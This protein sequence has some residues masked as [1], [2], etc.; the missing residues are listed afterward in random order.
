M[1]NRM[2]K[3]FK[4]GIFGML[5]FFGMNVNTQTKNAKSEIDQIQETLMKYID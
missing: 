2:I 3:A 1:T 4:I 5:I